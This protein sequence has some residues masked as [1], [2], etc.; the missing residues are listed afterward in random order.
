ATRA[1]RHAGTAPSAHRTEPAAFSTAPIRR[2]VPGAVARSRR[3]R[4]VIA[5]VA[6]WIVRRLAVPTARIVG[7]HGGFAAARR[8]LARRQG[9]W[10]GR[11]IAALL[12]AVVRILPR[13][14]AAVATLWRAP[15]PRE[16]LAAVPVRRIGAA[17]EAPEDAV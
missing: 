3:V 9:L 10:G 2:D 4:R 13:G 14:V 17:D 1:H 12:S 15:I 6:R 11:R 8:G 16:A 5:A 7:R